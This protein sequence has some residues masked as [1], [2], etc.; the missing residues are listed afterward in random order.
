MAAFGGLAAARLPAWS[1]SWREATGGELRG[2]PAL[3]RDGTLY[4]LSD[5]EYLYA[6]D[7]KARDPADRLRWKRRLGWLPADCLSV[8]LD[9]TV[10][11]GLKNGDFLAFNPRGE[12]L[13]RLRL[14]APP[15][16][17][18]SIS[19]DGTL[20]V[21]TASGT[22][23]AVSHLGRVEW[24]VTLPGAIV[25][26]PEMDGSG[27]IYLAAADRRLY[28]LTQ[29]GEFSWSLPLPEV[30]TA[31]AIGDRGLLV[32][33]GRD[34]LVTG[35][36]PEG[37]I[38]WRCRAGG[39]GVVGVSIGPDGISAA[40]DRGEIAELSETG[41]LRWRTKTGGRLGSAPLLDGFGME[42]LTSTG[43]L[44]TIDTAGALSS[45]PLGTS[46]PAALA[47]DGALYVGGRDWIVYALAPAAAA[48]PR[49]PWPEDGHDEAHTGRT[50]A[51]GPGAGAALLDGIPDYLY[52]R[53]L[54]AEN[55][56]EL[57]LLLL[58]D[59]RSR[60]ASGRL[61][62][63]TWYVVRMLE[64]LAGAGL[65]NPAYRSGRIVNDLPDVRAEAA[66][67]LGLV[68][69]SSSS[70]S[71]V[72]VIGEEYDSVA[73][74]EEIR[75]LGRIATDR[76]GAATR[77]IASAFYRKALFPPDDR[78]AEAAVGAL[79]GIA[80]YRGGIADP[81]AIEVLASIAR[82]DFADS[83]RAQALSA[84]RKVAN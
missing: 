65:V 22:L 71:L 20:Y 39:G 80:A 18:P 41:K 53:S 23:L 49:G 63:S 32:A 66:D 2:S 10:Y 46:G 30:A 13:W 77:A 11:C 34:G 8:G 75:A 48:W 76:D 45:T 44:C 25:L 12:L 64:R 79:A 54:S 58:S 55:T 4:A 24:K 61:G 6:F 67:L 57:D 47:R 33:G 3:S 17:D 72:E 35:I 78:V 16:G 7:S 1:V 26:A 59:I 69:T 84:L 52:L 83:T 15:A 28:A 68:G 31:L 36:D 56:R 74:A 42:I 70:R 60:I 21:A 82:A 38:V 81:S 27:E 14:G 51:R 37:D 73:L 29:W 43:S 40:T 50:D 62:K 5:D 19:A 9:G